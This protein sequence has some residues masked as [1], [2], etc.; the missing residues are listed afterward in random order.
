MVTHDNSPGRPNPRADV[1]QMLTRLDIEVLD[2]NLDGWRV[3]AKLSERCLLR[4]DDERCPDSRDRPNLYMIFLA[5][6]L[7]EADQRAFAMNLD[8]AMKFAGLG[9]TPPRELSNPAACERVL[10]TLREPLDKRLKEFD[11]TP[12]SLLLEALK[13]NRFGR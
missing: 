5:L 7:P 9:D 8:E 1:V 3:L 4:I 2:P 13:T 10:R 11:A 6:K 12:P